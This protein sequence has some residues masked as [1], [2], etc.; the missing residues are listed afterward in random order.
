[1]LARTGPNGVSGCK[2]HW[3]Q[4]QYLSQQLGVS[5]AEDGADALSALGKHFPNLRYIWLRRR[6]RLRQAISH[7]RAVQS[8][9]WWEI[10][11]ATRPP[12]APPQFDRDLI[13]ATIRDLE[14][15][16]LGWVTFFARCHLSPYVLWYEDFCENYQATI[17]NVLQYLDIP[18][19]DACVIT[20]PRLR[21]QADL[22]SEEWVRRYLDSTS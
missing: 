2:V 19:A 13:D 3:F 15:S 17:R 11:G 7:A 12:K 6:D 10:D 4:F 1:M 8:D 16:D 22:V 20:S 21:K 9:V 5:L 14:K 18:G